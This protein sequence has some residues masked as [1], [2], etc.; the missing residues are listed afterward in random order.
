MT[1]PLWSIVDL[2]E[3]LVG[4]DTVLATLS[5]GDD[6]RLEIHGLSLDSRLG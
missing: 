5:S 4:D 2:F 1:M 3:G 6:A